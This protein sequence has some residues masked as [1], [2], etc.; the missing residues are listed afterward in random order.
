MSFRAVCLV[1]MSAGQNSLR[2]TILISR[3]PQTRLFVF[4]SVFPLGKSQLVKYSLYYLCV[5]LVLMICC[6][7]SMVTRLG[8]LSRLII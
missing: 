2:A 4:V 1:E 8:W 3:T 6:L 7:K 5:N